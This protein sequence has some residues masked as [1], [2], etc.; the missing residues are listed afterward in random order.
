MDRGDGSGTGSIGGSIAGSSRSVLSA[1]G[2][3]EEVSGGRHEHLSRTGG[4][5]RAGAVVGPSAEC[6][7]PERS[8]VVRIGGVS[9]PEADLEFLLLQDIGVEPVSNGHETP[10]TNIL[11]W[12]GDLDPMKVGLHV[13]H[14]EVAER[15]RVPLSPA[16]HHASAWEE[17][18]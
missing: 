9:I 11:I 8:A 7:D 16:E 15:S 17:V 14:Q 10:V 18:S 5:D 13:V 3:T 4:T 2:C 6:G 12:S 1:S